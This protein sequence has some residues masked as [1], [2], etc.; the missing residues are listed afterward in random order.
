MFKN[1]RGI[2]HLA[3]L[4]IIAIG[5]FA[6]LYL[7]GQTQIFKPKAFERSVDVLMQ[8]HLNGTQAVF[9]WR[10]NNPTSPTNSPI[11]VDM[12]TRPQMDSDVYLSFAIATNAPEIDGNARN[13][14]V[15]IDNPQARWAKYT[16][17]ATLY[18]RVTNS[19]RTIYSQIFPATVN[20]ASQPQL[21]ES[22]C[23]RSATDTYSRNKF[24]IAAHPSDTDDRTLCMPI[25]TTNA[26]DGCIRDIL[27]QV[28]EAM[29]N[30][31]RLA[32]FANT[33]LCTNQ[34]PPLTICEPQRPTTGCITVLPENTTCWTQGGGVQETA[35]NWCR[36]NAE[37]VGQLVTGCGQLKSD[38][39]GVPSFQ[40]DDGCYVFGQ[41]PSAPVATP[42]PSAVP[43]ELTSG[44]IHC[45]IFALQVY[46]PATNDCRTINPWGVTCPSTNTPNLNPAALCELANGNQHSCNAF[47]V[48]TYNSDD[49]T[50]VPR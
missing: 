2:V 12:S 21:T 39:Y 48:C 25:S 50:C 3:P 33:P 18:W 15:A 20:C 24:C 44:P 49:N 32:S 19:G 8:A 40:R 41:D 34:Q 4:I 16:C 5:L 47:G 31:C 17:N 13:Y 42:A 35:N 22:S 45:N 9:E 14:L 27:T 6:L 23:W 37:Y 30:A 11:I 43:L 29:S 28:K 10:D 46:C 36:Q 1:K 26:S 38:G 7:T